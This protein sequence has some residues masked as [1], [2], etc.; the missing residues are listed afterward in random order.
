MSNIKPDIYPPYT[1]IR[2]ILPENLS[3]ITD[4]FRAIILES[5]KSLDA[6]DLSWELCQV[7]IVANSQLA[8][9][10]FEEYGA[11]GCEEDK[12]LAKVRFEEFSLRQA[13]PIYGRWYSVIISDKVSKNAIYF[14]IEA[15]TVSNDD[16]VQNPWLLLKGQQVVAEI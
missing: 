16:K 5:M 9:N 15:V 14:I 11:I 8:D 3:V 6:V 4:W 2:A 13:L 12:Q 7:F 10:I 1:V